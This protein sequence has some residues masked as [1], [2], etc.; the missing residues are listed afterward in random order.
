MTILQRIVSRLQRHTWIAA[1]I[2][3]DVDALHT[4]IELNHRE[5][6]FDPNR[7]GILA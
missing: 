1:E 6:G 2:E 5:L 3:D 4:S 7:D